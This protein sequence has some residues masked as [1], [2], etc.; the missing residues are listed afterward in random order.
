M[1]VPPMYNTFFLKHLF[2]IFLK[3]STNWDTHGYL[4]FGSQLQDVCRHSAGDP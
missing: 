2:L 3:K 1:G 4:R